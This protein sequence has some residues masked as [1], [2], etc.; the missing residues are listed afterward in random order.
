M[1]NKS[2][3]KSCHKEGFEEGEVYG[4][5]KIFFG[6]LVSEPRLKIIN[7]LRNG[8]KNVTEI[9]EELDLDQTS[10]SHDL[11]RLK[12]CGF[13]EQEID[14]KFRYYKLNE[15]TIK[16]LMN[17]IDKHMAGNCIHILKENYKGGKK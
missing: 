8:K 4:A 2:I 12:K 6:T 10:V 1:I 14:G 17:L 3:L 7:F 9:V 15:E 16:P 5:Y 11:Q 13:I